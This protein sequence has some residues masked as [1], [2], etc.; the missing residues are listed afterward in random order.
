M[1]TWST[2]RLK[3]FHNE[4]RA[5][6]DVKRQTWLNIISLPLPYVSSV[7]NVETH[8][9]SDTELMNTQI[10]VIDTV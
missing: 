8:L 2:S 10:S 6:S 1:E 3:Q 5:Q 4:S 9:H 7:K